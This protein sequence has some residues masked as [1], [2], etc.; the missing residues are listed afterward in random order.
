MA[1]GDYS[2]TKGAPKI[3]NRSGMPEIGKP[4]FEGYTDPYLNQ[5]ERAFDPTNVVSTLQETLAAQKKAGQTIAQTTT[6]NVSTENFNGGILN[7]PFVV[8]NANASAFECVFWIETVNN[9]NKGANPT[10]QQL[11]YFQQ[12]NLN[13]LPKFNEKGLIMWPHT[14]VNTL[15]KQ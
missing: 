2:I 4:K 7:I 12:T 15:A 14:N 10:F 13:F 1:L 5:P 3:Q 11:Q 8:K 6:L 9:P